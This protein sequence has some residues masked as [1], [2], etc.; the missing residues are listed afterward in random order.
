MKKPDY[1]SFCGETN[2]TF[3]KDYLVFNPDLEIEE[4]ED[5]W[6]CTKCRTIHVDKI[7]NV[8]YQFE[9]DNNKEI[10]QDNK[11]IENWT[12]N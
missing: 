11:S 1:C 4:K 6:I 5:C 2:L 3:V 7:A 9:I 8:F 12:I 10:Q